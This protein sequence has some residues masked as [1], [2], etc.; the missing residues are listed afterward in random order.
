M[1][2]LSIYLGVLFWGLLRSVTLAQSNPT[3]KDGVITLKNGTQRTCAISF[4]ETISGFI[5]ITSNSGT[6]S[7]L[8]ASDV[9]NIRFS[10]GEIICSK[11]VSYTED[12][13]NS[14]AKHIFLQ[15]QVQGTISVYKSYD[16]HFNLVVEKNDELQAIQLVTIDEGGE[17]ITVKHFR[18]LLKVMTDEYGL[19][20]NLNYSAMVRA[21]VDVCK[22]FSALGSI[23][24][25]QRS[26]DKSYVEQQFYTLSFSNSMRP[27]F[28]IYYRF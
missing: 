4:D 24:H 25:K 8:M 20:D 7:N 1:K 28:G 26:E 22:S 16:Y 21:C 19:P 13:K 6:S 3:N 15:L 14:I 18:E 2:H 23:F 9:D 12:T 27:E 17:P 10:S 11:E 5:T